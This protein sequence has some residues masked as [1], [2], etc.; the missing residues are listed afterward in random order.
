MGDHPPQGGD[1]SDWFIRWLDL[2]GECEQ[3]RGRLIDDYIKV[4]VLLERVPK[5]LKDH[6]VVDSPQFA[7]AENKFPMMR[8]IVQ[9]WCRS[10]KTFASHRSSVEIAAVSTAVSESEESVSALGWHGSWPEQRPGKSKGKEEGKSKSN[11]GKGK[12]WMVD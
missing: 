12:R 6:L 11:S 4:A 8:E 10:R 3:A 5:E 1:F 7:N 9:R 2:I